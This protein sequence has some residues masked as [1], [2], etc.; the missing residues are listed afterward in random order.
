MENSLVPARVLSAV[1]EAVSSEALE[2]RWAEES[3]I[4]LRTLIKE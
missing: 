1:L 4:Y 3:V 2:R